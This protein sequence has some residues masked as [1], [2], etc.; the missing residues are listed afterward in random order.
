MCN[1]GLAKSVAN[2]C[3]ILLSA[4]FIN[5]YFTSA[6]TAAFTDRMWASTVTQLNKGKVTP[7]E[8]YPCLHY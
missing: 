1:S 6:H 8:I 2:F 7:V 5:G 4:V 3:C